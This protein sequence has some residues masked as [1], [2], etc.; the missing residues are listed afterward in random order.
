VE[1]AHAGLELFGL[2]RELL[3]GGGEFLGGRG[4]VLDDLIKLLQGLV[5]LL[6]AG[7]LFLARGVDLLDEVGRALDVGHELGEQ[8]AGPFGHAGGSCARVR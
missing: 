4:V 1:K 8:V 6:G 5:D 3:G 7:G 2:G